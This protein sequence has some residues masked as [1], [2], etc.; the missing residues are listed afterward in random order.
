MYFSY[1]KR[2]SNVARRLHPKNFG[3]APQI[4]VF[5]GTRTSHTAKK[6]KKLHIYRREYVVVSAIQLSSTF[7][8]S[9]IVKNH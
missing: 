3:S 6:K 9:N 2:L 5:D 8:L 4:D 1:A 7:T